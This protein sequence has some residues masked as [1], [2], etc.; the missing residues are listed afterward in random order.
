MLLQL[1]WSEYLRFLSA[2]VQILF[3]P[4][5]TKHLLQQEKKCLSWPT[6][7]GNIYGSTFLPVKH[8]NKKLEIIKIQKINNLDFSFSFLPANKK[9]K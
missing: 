9:I 2:D 4:P 3:I 5:D 6:F 1:L 8:K 7:C